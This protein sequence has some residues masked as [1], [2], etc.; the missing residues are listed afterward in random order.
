MKTRLALSISVLA[1][2][3]MAQ[4]QA[5]PAEV[6][7]DA[8]PKEVCQAIAQNTKAKNFEAVQKLTAGMA[9]NQKTAK[10]AKAGFNQMHSKQMETLQDLNCGNEMKTEDHAMVEAEAKGEKRLIPFVKTA[11][12]W[13][14]DMKTYRA[15]YDADQKSSAKN[16]KM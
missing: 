8:T 7:A 16:K 6:K 5:A 4:D 15:F 9:S 12:G 3:A 1:F 2:T 13:K 14:F 11:E 10:K